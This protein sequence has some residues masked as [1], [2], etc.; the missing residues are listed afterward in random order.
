M[1]KLSSHG[2]FGWPACV[3]AHERTGLGARPRGHCPGLPASAGRWAAGGLVSHFWLLHHALLCHIWWLPQW[4]GCQAACRWY[5]CPGACTG[6]RESEIMCLSQ[7]RRSGG[8]VLFQLWASW[9][10]GYYR[11]LH[12]ASPVP[13][14][15]WYVVGAS[16]INLKGMKEGTKFASPAKI[17]V[18]VS[19]T[20]GIW[21]KETETRQH[22]FS[23][24]EEAEELR[25]SKVHE[26]GRTHRGLQKASRCVNHSLIHSTNVYWTLTMCQALFSLL[27][28][29][30]K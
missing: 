19:E 13:R 26:A 7:D 23:A 17:P 22:V 4:G 18:H 27:R 3:Y 29:R 28:Y 16:Q 9:T 12:H 24:Q 21:S 6:R 20:R 30:S 25:W 11:P 10:Q 2:Q 5:S 1:R 8:K 15:V 14:M